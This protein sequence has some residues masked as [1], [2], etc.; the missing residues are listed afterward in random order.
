MVAPGPLI[1]RPLVKGSEDSANEIERDSA[2]MFSQL[3]DRA[4]LD[5]SALL[6]FQSFTEKPVSS[7][8]SSYDINFAILGSKHYRSRLC[9]MPQISHEMVSNAHVHQLTLFL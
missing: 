1:F 6:D 7:V 9:D 8:C 2:S 4:D 5:T 3:W